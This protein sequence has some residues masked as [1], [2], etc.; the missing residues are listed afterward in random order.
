MQEPANSALFSQPQLV[1]A[2]GVANITFNTW[3]KRNNLFPRT[4][5]D[6]KWNKYTIA[7]VA[8]SKIVKNLTS[9]GITA[10]KAVDVAM[11]ILPILNVLAD[12][13]TVEAIDKR[14]AV[15][16]N[17][18]K[19]QPSIFYLEYGTPLTARNFESTMTIATCILIDVVEV[20][21][22]CVDAI[23]PGSVNDDEELV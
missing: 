4:N 10:Q 8:A 1:D 17:L 11:A 16:K 15:V 14:I 22:D 7:E 12:P 9:I 5:S 3:R 13:S 23:A 19:D 6:R 2:I 18:D 21:Y 20:L